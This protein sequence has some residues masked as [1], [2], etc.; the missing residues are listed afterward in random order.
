MQ[1]CCGSWPMCRCPGARRASTTRAS[2]RS[3]AGSGS[4]TW[5]QDSLLSWTPRA[6]KSLDG[7][8]LAVRDRCAG[9]D[10]GRW[11][12]TGRDS[13]GRGRSRPHG[14]G[15]AGEQGEQDQQRHGEKT[16]WF[17]A[18]FPFRRDGRGRQRR[19][20]RPDW[21]VARGGR[22]SAPVGVAVNGR[23]HRPAMLLPGMPD[24][25]A[26]CGLKAAEAVGG[27]PGAQMAHGRHRLPDSGD[28]QV[29]LID[30]DVAP[31]LLRDDEPPAGHR[32]RRF[33]AAHPGSG[34][35]PYPSRSAPHRTRWGRRLC[36][37]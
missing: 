8:S 14:D 7:C 18:R 23:A 15:A 10:G 17:H 2:I 33:V 5:A 37:R 25:M 27:R 1:P 20:A 19:R 28:D 36:Y 3:P 21:I 9:D 6:G 35:P 13:G 4:P 22:G 30:H 32:G 24:V 29:Q 12:G 11:T 34:A 31:A 26:R 16:P